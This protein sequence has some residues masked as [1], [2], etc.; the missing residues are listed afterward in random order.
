MSARERLAHEVEYDRAMGAGEHAH[1][2]PVMCGGCGDDTCSECGYV[3][4]V[5]RCE[6]CCIQS[7]EALTGMSREALVEARWGQ[8]S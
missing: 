7:V 1:E 6:E 8:P 3:G 5:V 2:N 4:F